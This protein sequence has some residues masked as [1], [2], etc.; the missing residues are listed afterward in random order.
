MGG[1]PGPSITLPGRKQE[2]THGGLSAES[3]GGGE[4]GGGGFVTLDKMQADVRKVSRKGGGG[5]G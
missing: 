4:G 3:A 5:A 1:A 2:E